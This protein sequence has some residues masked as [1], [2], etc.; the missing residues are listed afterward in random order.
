VYSRVRARVRR[1][2]ATAPIALISRSPC[3]S[4][5]I[6]LKPSPSTPSSASPG[7]RTPSRC[8]SAVS[9][10]RIPTLSSF[11]ATSKP[12]RSVS[13]RNSEMPPHG[14]AGSRSAVRTTMVTKSARVPLVM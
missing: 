7:T 8:S 3:S 4:H 10:A 11:C 13:T 2:P 14:S 1:A 5:M 9:E 6:C 12:G